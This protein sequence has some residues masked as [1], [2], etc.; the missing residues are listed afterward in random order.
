MKQRNLAIDDRPFPHSAFNLGVFLMYN[1][2]FWH[3]FGSE[4]HL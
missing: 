4:G 1:N 3:G 2:Q